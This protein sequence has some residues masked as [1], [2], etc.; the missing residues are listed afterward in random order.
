MRGCSRSSSL[1]EVKPQ[2]TKCTIFRAALKTAGDDR[3]DS[4]PRMVFSLPTRMFQPDSVR[5]ADKNEAAGAADA[6][7]VQV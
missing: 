4:V 7:R 5:L 2:P 6:S 1:A 3:A